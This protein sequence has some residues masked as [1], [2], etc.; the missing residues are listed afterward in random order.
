MRCSAALRKRVVEFVQ[1][2]STAEA[3]RRF[4]VGEASVYH[5]LKSGRSQHQ[6]PGPKNSRELDREDLL[7]HV[8]KYD[9]MTQ[10]ERAHHL[11]VPR[12]CIWKALQ[13]MGVTRKK[14]T[15][16][17]SAVLCKQ[18][19]VCACVNGF[20]AVANSPS[21]SMSAGLRLPLR[22]ATVMR[23]RASMFTVLSPDI[24]GRE[25]P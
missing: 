1:G 3:A 17:K 7:C 4:K 19:D 9:D 14:M 21:I 24:G 15:A 2:G 6:W 8:E 20:F 10:R 13:K 23:S 11:R 12:Y 16:T 18:E 25:P 5:W 22:G